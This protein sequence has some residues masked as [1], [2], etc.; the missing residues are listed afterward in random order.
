MGSLR[1]L[2]SAG[3]QPGRIETIVLRPARGV[4]AVVV[5][6]A[7]L[8]EGRGLLGDRHAART[9]LGVNGQARALTLIQAEHLPLLA[10]WTGGERID[11]ALLR[12]NLVVSGLNLLGLRSPFADQPRLWRIGPSAVIEVS[13]PCEPCSRMEDVIDPGGYNAMRGH[14]G[15]YALVVSG[16]LWRRGDL[17]QALCG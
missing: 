16:G 12:R 9:A 15:V 2:I 7:E 1:E 13:G 11:P 14:G 8:V 10:R 6:E 17:L 5:D 3:P 4:A